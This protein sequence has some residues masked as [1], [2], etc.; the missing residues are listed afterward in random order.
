[1]KGRRLIAGILAAV[2]AST[3]CSFIEPEVGDRQGA[4]VDAD[5][6]PAHDVSFKDQIRPIMRGPPVGTRACTDCHR[7]GYPG[8]DQTGLDLTTLG[9]LRAG[10]SRSH[11][12][13]VVPESPCSSVLVQK[14]LGTFQGTRMPMGGPYWTTAQI[15][16]VKDWIAEGAKG[17]D[18]E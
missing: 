15:Q 8:Y 6:D 17:A 16:L 11:G 3:A 7:P 10:G 1:V 18:D 5:S 9:L 12:T 4:C 13:I 14:L 2:V